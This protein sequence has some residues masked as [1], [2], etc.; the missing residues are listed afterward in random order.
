M[1]TVMLFQNDAPH[2]AH[3]V[4]GE[5]IDCEFV[6][7]E[8]GLSPPDTEAYTGRIADRV[9]TGGSVGNADLVIAEGTAPL[10]TGF[11]A[12]VRSGATLVYLCADQTF[13]T[14][15]RRKTEVV[16]RLLP[17]VVDGVIA[18]SDL[19]HS[20][21]SPYIDAPCEIVRPPIM[22]E[23]HEYLRAATP[24]SPEGPIVSMG[25]TRA[26]KN[27]ERLP[28]IAE[29]TGREMVVLGSGHDEQAYTDHDAVT[30]PGWV[31]IPKLAE[32]LEEAALYVQPSTGDA[33][34]VASMEAMLSGTPVLV[35]DKAGTKELGVRHVPLD[36]FGAET[37]AYLEESRETR[38]RDGESNRGRVME[39]TEDRQGTRFR[40]AIARW[41]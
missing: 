34:P 3:R 5:A 37:A 19:A 12:S 6:H 24:G 27:F 28:E 36:R 31:S 25:R 38:E 8:T 35:S 23:K 2:P 21:A 41:T 16:W 40:E 9:R 30:A 1:R 20:W 33:C 29:R 22:N 10:Q 18:V 26:Q 32:I 14:L 4:F 39:F 15:R 17:N 11:V 7:F 13:R